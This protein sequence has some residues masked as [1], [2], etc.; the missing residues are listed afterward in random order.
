M[1]PCTVRMNVSNCV[2]GYTIA[3]SN[4]QISCVLTAIL[5]HHPL[6]L[7]DLF[8]LTNIRLSELGVTTTASL[9][10]VG[11][12]TH[13]H[14]DWC[15]G[16]NLFGGVWC[17]DGICDWCIEK[18]LQIQSTSTLLNGDGDI[19]LLGN[20]AGVI[21]VGDVDFGQVVHGIC[22]VHAKDSESW[23]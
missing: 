8:D 1:T 16:M 5:F 12:F 11:D 20:N 9:G 4:V 14:L 15:L 7:Q 21:R 6:V 22:R 10:V 13:Q 2:F 17:L 19:V 18:K 23:E 3:L